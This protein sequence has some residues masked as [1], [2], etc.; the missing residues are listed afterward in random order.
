MG[1]IMPGIFDPRFFILPAVL[2]AL[3]FACSRGPQGAPKPDD[4]SATGSD[5]AWPKNAPPRSAC[6]KDEDCAIVPVAPAGPD[7]CC[8]ITVTAMPLSVRFLQWMESWREKNCAGVACPPLRLPG[9]LLADC[10][11]K[12]RCD[13]GKCANA[14]NAAVP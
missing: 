1:E 5:R 13:G 9:A 8:E 12:P 3:P 11:Y 2:S 6:E 14:C 10:G 7:P 4:Q